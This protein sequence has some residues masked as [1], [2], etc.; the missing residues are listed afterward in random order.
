VEKIWPSLAPCFKPKKGNPDRLIQPRI[1]KE[2]KLQRKRRK[3]QSETGRKGADARWGKDQEDKELD[4]DPNA[5]AM[6]NDGLAVAVASSTAITTTNT[7]YPSS[8]ETAWQ[9]YPQRYGD[10]P[11][12]AAFKAWEA[13]RKEGVSVDELI[14]ATKAY[15]AFCFV[16]KKEGTEFVMQARTFYGPN[17]RWKEYL[18]KAVKETERIIEHAQPLPEMSEEDR[19]AQLDEIRK[20]KEELAARK[21][22]E[23]EVSA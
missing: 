6:P 3:K 8:F 11:K 19:A 7:T 12:K 22:G 16:T 15:A 2:R 14:K 10:N 5:S 4:G 23:S 9:F 20:A 1:E 18:D 13:R 17:E 21:R